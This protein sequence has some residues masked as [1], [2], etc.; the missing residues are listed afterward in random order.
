MQVIVKYHD[1]DSLLIEEVIKQ[2]KDN[3]GAQA[4]VKVLPE[5]DTPIDYLYFALQ[6]LI[7][8]EHLSLLYDSGSTYHQDLGKLRAEALFKVGEV[9]NEVIMDNEGRL[10]Q[11][12]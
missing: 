12:E 10:L 3:Y 9:L 1:N 5:S 4:S 8:G 6:R 2:A 11:G 7:T